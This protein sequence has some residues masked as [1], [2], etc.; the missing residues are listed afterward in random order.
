[1]GRKWRKIVFIAVVCLVLGGGVLY[2]YGGSDSGP[3][4]HRLRLGNEEPAKY[5]QG[6][7]VLTQDQM[8]LSLGHQSQP[9][10]Y[11]SIYNHSEIL[12]KKPVTIPAG[13]GQLIK[14]T[15]GGSAVFPAPEVI[16]YWL[17]IQRP[18]EHAEDNLVT[19]YIEAKVLG[20]DEE[21]AADKLLKLAE[22]WEVL[23]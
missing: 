16:Y 8:E 2:L 6:M 17:C 3:A 1:M 9:D 21:A 23:D 22:N 7:D 20:G 15:Q 5:L 13:E 12:W 10:G 4:V 19:Y 14:F 18:G 11:I